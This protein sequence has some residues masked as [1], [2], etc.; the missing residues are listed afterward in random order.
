M[1]S[2]GN[3]LM[4][5]HL[6]AEYRQG[7]RFLTQWAGYPVTDAT[8][9]PMKAFVH[10]D[11]TLKELFVELCLAGAPKY[12]TCMRTARTPGQKYK[13]SRTL[14]KTPLQG[15]RRKKLILRLVPHYVECRTLS[16][17]PQPRSQRQRL[18]IPRMHNEFQEREGGKVQTVPD[19]L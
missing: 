11:G 1:K 12:G 17:I 13:N 10:A 16:H 3:Y 4:E 9:E 6:K 18:S 19:R 5:Q 14:K 2:Q 15:H 7:W 8:W